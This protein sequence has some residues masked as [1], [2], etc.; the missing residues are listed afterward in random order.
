MKKIWLWCL[1]ALWFLL[2]NCT[3]NAI[4]N[5]T[6]EESR[7]Y[8]TNY[9]TT[10]NFH[11]YRT[12][13]ISD[14]VALVRNNQ[15]LAKRVDEVYTRFIAAFAQSLEARGYVR[16]AREAN[17]DL[18]IALSQITNTTTNLISYNDYGNYYGGYWDP[19]YWDYPGYNYYF[20]TY[21]GTYQTSET[22]LAIDMFDLK[23]SSQNNQIKDVW[24]GMIRG[25][26]I[27]T[28]ANVDSQVAALLQQSSYLQTQ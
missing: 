13:Y 6:T 28:L 27:F 15:L 5:L 22:V 8:I 12:F 14:S 10:A 24:S 18:G 26:G 17:P 25:S 19:F 2:S 9:D 21:Y 11:T 1:P 4:D 23:N 7:I 16:V 20:P 3:K